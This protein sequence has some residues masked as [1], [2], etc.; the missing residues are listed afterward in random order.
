MVYDFFI[1]PSLGIINIEPL[2][3]AP[4]VIEGANI[5]ETTPS[6]GGGT[7][8]TPT[9]TNG[10][11]TTP[12]PTPL[13]QSG[14]PEADF[15]AVPTL[16]PAPLNVQFT[17]AS[18]GGPT[19]WFWEFSD[20]GTAFEQNPSHLFQQEGLFTIKLEV[21][22][23]FGNDTIE[24]PDFIS[25]KASGGLQADF[26]VD[27]ALGFVPLTVKFTDLSN[28]D[29]TGWLWKFGDGGNTDT[30]NP[31]HTYLVDGIFNV[32]LTAT[33]GTVISIENKINLI[34]A[35]ENRP[36]ANFKASATA[37]QIP[38]EV[39]FTDLSQPVGNIGSWTWDFG[40]GKSSTEQNPTHKFETE[41]FF[42]IELT[43]SNDTGADS[44]RKTNL[45]V[46]LGQ[47]V[48]VAQFKASTTAGLAPLDVIFTDQSE[49]SGDIG[50]YVWTFGDG[51]ISTEE[52]PEHK[53]NNEGI[54]T[55]GITVSNSFG[56]DSEV[57]PNIISVIDETDDVI[58]AFSVNPVIG[59]I[60]ANIEFVNNS[61]GTVVESIWN[62]GDGIEINEPGNDNISHTYREPGEYDIS[63]TVKGSTD[64][65]DTETKSK[66]IKIIE[67][68]GVAAGFNGTPVIG[69]GPLEVQFIDKSVGEV[70]SW[71]WDFGDGGAKATEA[72]PKHTFFEKGKYDVKLIVNSTDGKADT[73]VRNDFIEVLEDA[74]DEDSKDDGDDKED[75][76]NDNDSQEIAELSASTSSIPRSKNG[77]EVTITAFDEDDN[78]I[79]GVSIRAETFGRSSFV[80]PTVGKTDSRGQAKFLVGFKTFRK[81]SSV[82]FSADGVTT[83]VKQN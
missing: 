14:E 9:P 12:T 5:V 40:D 35:T 6:T 18:K 53:Y 43:I 49:P 10:G 66:V 31:A 52:N 65:E 74:E 64:N 45:I 21:S 63:L 22:N 25:V 24:K 59:I 46:A 73:T 2:A 69:S 37:G 80:E 11:G 82:E 7:T 28:G 56:A 61:G 62:F 76:D 44:A 81:I 34:T 57:K 42:S 55:V 20:G 17:D 60:P 71:E 1:D 51:G 79:E 38:F 23:S 27:K 32:E 33:K 29:P 78:P 54:Y 39:K 70:G 47:N 26:T 77:V 3:T 68:G 15:L 58:A 8:T 83:T 75:G 16:G 67:A 30:Q 36:S 50:S 19:G 4:F 72:N 48:P 13:V 41:G